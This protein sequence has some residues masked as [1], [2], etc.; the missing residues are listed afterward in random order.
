MS[1]LG[2]RCAVEWRESAADAAEAG[3]GDAAPVVPFSLDWAAGTRAKALASVS[4]LCAALLTRHSHAPQTS[5]VGPLP[6][7]VMC[8]FPALAI[9]DSVLLAAQRPAAAWLCATTDS[10]V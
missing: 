4:H 9:E 6:E 8:L 7:V 1:W 10:D 2:L 3:A 5:V